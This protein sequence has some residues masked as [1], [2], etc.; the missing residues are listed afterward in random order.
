MVHCTPPATLPEG[1]PEKNSQVNGFRPQGC[2]GAGSADIIGRA[3]S[4]HRLPE[5]KKAVVA[6]LAHARGH[7][8]CIQPYDPATASST[9]CCLLCCQPEPM[10]QFLAARIALFTPRNPCRLPAW[11]G[12]GIHM[13]YRTYH[14][15]LHFHSHTSRR[16]TGEY[17][18]GKSCQPPGLRVIWQCKHWARQKRP[19]AA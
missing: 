6:Q 9:G 17:L 10:S 19:Q 12:Q 3:R 16:M 13:H 5:T 11:R 2:L 18:P 15:P 14:V 4:L 7:C 1:W 8:A